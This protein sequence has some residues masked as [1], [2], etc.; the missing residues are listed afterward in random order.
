M[1]NAIDYNASGDYESDAISNITN[2][3]DKFLNQG[4]EKFQFASRTL[5]L[6]KYAEEAGLGPISKQLTIDRFKTILA[7]IMMIKILQAIR[8]DGL[9][10]LTITGIAVV[11]LKNKHRIKE[12]FN[13]H[14]YIENK[15]KEQDN[16]G[17]YGDFGR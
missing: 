3:A 7:G 14:L 9:K 17:Y 12:L 15:M 6:D 11:G 1:N 16:L 13:K 2:M 4:Y 5:E 8:T 10:Y